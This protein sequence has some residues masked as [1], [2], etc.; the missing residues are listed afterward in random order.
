MKGLVWGKIEE[1]VSDRQW[2]PCMRKPV[3]GDGMRHAE[4]A[5]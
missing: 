4:K 2:A 5:G 3:V 1:A